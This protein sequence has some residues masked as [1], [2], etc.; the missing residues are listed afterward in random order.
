M[1]QGAE[2]VIFRNE[3]L[4]HN[5]EE[6]SNEWEND[7]VFKKQYWENCLSIH[8]NRKCDLLLILLSSKS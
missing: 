6:I 5:E 4:L 7:K 3:K 1:D 8:K 2:K